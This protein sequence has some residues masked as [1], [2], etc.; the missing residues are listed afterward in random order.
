[1]RAEKIQIDLEWKNKHEIV[2]NLLRVQEADFLSKIRT[3]EA[4]NSSLSAKVREL[5]V[6]L[7]DYN[8]IRVENNE[9]KH[10]FKEENDRKVNQAA[11]IV[12]TG[13]SG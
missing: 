3:H 9:M 6:I 12:R 4:V 10:F 7:G 8:L 2:S 1:L 11:E 5:E 13:L